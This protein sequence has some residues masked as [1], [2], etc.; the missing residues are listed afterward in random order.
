MKETGYIKVRNYRGCTARY[1][2]V[3]SKLHGARVKVLRQSPATGQLTVTFLES[4]AGTCYEPG[5]E[6]SVAPYEI[7]VETQGAKPS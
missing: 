2:G 1:K 6:I 4:V 3:H 7:E 5:V